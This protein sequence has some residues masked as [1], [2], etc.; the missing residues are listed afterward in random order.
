MG[1]DGSNGANA[2]TLSGIVRSDIRS[3][4]AGLS[5]TAAGVPLTLNRQRGGSH[6]A[7]L[8]VGIPA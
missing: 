1:G 5:G 4:I 7:A 6:V 8:T 2:L 3:S